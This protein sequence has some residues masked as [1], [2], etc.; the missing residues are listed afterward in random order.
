MVSFLVRIVYLFMKAG[1]VCIVDMKY[2][3]T[4]KYYKI[5]IYHQYS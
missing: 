1:L 3:L 4:Q 5:C 2:K